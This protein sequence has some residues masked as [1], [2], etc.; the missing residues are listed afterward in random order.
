ME[1]IDV[2]ILVSVVLLALAILGLVVDRWYDTDAHRD[3]RR[4]N[5]PMARRV[6]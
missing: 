6:R 1:P 3:A 5:G 2:A 4:R